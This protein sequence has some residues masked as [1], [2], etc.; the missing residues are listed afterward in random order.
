MVMV[1]VVRNGQSNPSSTLD[2]AVYISHNGKILGKD[3]NLTILLPSIVQ[4]SGRMV[5]PLF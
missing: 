1:M 3:M 5:W 4:L 2:E